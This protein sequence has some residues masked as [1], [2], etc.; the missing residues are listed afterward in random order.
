MAATITTEDTRAMGGR[1]ASEA[2]AAGAAVPPEPPQPAD[3]EAPRDAATVTAPL[4][5]AAPEIVV[6]EVLGSTTGADS[7]Y[8]ELFGPPGA[9]LAGLSLIVV[10]SDEGP[11]AG[12][13]DFRQ[14]FEAGA[15]LGA[16][17]FF[18]LANGTAAQTYGVTPDVAIAENAI[19]NSAYTVALVQTAGLGEVVTGSETVLDAVAVTGPDGGRFVFDAPVIGPDGDFLPA[20]VGR[21]AVG[22]DTDAAADFAILSFA[23]SS[24]PNTPTAAGDGG[25]DA[26]GGGDLAIGADPTPISAVQGAGDASPLLGQTVVVE[27]IVTGDFQTGD[28]D[29]L[30]DLGGFF[31]MEERSD[32]DGDAAT[33][34]GVFASEGD[35]VVD[36]E[37][38]D[39]V[40][41]L[42]EVVER[43][44]KT[45]IEVRE[46]RVEEA[47]AV[48]D[49]LS[50]AVE[51]T[52]P[53]IEAREALESMLVTVTEPLTF[54]ESFD[55]EQFGEAT[56][57]AG[58]P[59]YQFTQL[60]EPDPEAAAAYAEAVADRTVTIDDG[61]DGRRDDFDPIRQPDGELFAVDGGVRMGQEL[62]SLTAIVDYGFGE[63]RLR[64]P[65]G[66]AFDPVEATNP[67]PAGPPEVGSDFKVASF[68]VLNYFTTLDADGALTDIG[69]E[70]RGA[71]SPD[72]LERQSAKLVSALL[73]LDADVIGLV[74]IEND[75]AGDDAAIAELVSRLN[76]AAG[77][78]RYAFVDPGQA[79]VGPDAIAVGFL[80]DA[81]T[82]E[83][84]GAP[85]ILD[86]PSF[87][88][89]LDDGDD[90]NGDE[91]PAGD[92]F[93]RA[94]LAQTFR[95]AA[96]GGEFLAV[97]NHFKSKGSPTGAPADEDGGDGAGR[98][99]ATRAEAA[100]ELLEFVAGDPTGT[101]EGDVLILGDLNAYARETPIQVLEDGGF[102]DLARVFE[103]AD[104]SSYRFSGQIGTLDYALA[105]ESLRLQVTGAATWNINADEL[106]I[107]DYNEEATFGSP[108]LRPDGQGLFDG[109]DPARSSDHDPVVVGLDLRPE[110][111]PLVVTGTPGVDRLLGTDAPEIIDARGGRFD[112]VRGGGGA[113]VFRFTDTEGRRDALFVADFDADEDA[114]AL[115]GAE[116]ADARA[117]GGNL[118]L[119]LVEDR[120]VIL[121][122]GVDDLAEVN[123]VDDPLALV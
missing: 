45:T 15:R 106:V 89:P 116:I 67:R 30:R 39:R 52:L 98:N 64:L 58:G 34:E 48:A 44:G 3:R 80:Y 61:T 14:D 18:L 99:D 7:E 12:A 72:E 86:A 78:D 63:F 41:V 4:A 9:S 60:N 112:L 29:A 53:G 110:D 90:A 57:A 31:L 23:N 66:A 79:F 111:A 76:A 43:F 104:V 36:V 118:L 69:L 95:E 2:P 93:N 92:A 77:T 96:S 49:V 105:D 37:A 42:G 1:A 88:D 97:V 71:E 35:L 19:E 74:E 8:V 103:G 5:D 75:F 70:P 55:I 108:V 109:S 47:R 24:P 38:G 107:F 54:V 85:A 100:R 73:A 82:V 10:E 83:L 115:A 114:L 102:T 59:V 17:G 25:G 119:R 51:T 120:D 50:L 33:S 6:N 13:I 113:D 65:E 91:T 46:I 101:G 27:G 40:R 20:G 62:R 26:G 94:A 21:V 11:S 121:L 28:A 87:L 22:V 117:L 122:R 32:F 81:S 68:N 16:N 56:L 123:F 84:V